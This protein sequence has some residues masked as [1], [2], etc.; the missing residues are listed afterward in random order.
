M[1]ASASAKAASMLGYAST[2]SQT[3][4]PSSITRM[5]ERVQSVGPSSIHPLLTHAAT[6]GK[7][8]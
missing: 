6:S 8:S 4:P 2:P 5:N 7:R 3:V 1:A